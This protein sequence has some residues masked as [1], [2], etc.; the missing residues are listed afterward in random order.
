MGAFYRCLHGS[1]LKPARGIYSTSWKLNNILKGIAVYIFAGADLRSMGNHPHPSYPVQYPERR[2]FGYGGCRRIID[3]IQWRENCWRSQP[4]PA[5]ISSISQSLRPA[6][7]SPAMF[8]IP[9]INDSIDE[10]SPLRPSHRCHRAC[11]RS[12]VLSTMIN[13]YIYIAPCL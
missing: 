8:H 9:L 6:I 5:C 7:R 12:E 13:F 4:C 1:R 10:M 11:V 2:R 3:F